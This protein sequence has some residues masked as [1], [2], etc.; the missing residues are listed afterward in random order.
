MIIAVNKLMA[1]CV[2]GRTHLSSDNPSSL[3]RNLK[4]LA[5]CSLFL[6][7]VS[8]TPIA[9][10]DSITHGEEEPAIIMGSPGVTTRFIL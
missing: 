5:L 3:V 6:S 9:D 4:I 10:T 1:L 7:A 2:V 8:V